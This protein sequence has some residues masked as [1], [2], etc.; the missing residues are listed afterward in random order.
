MKTKIAMKIL[1]SYT[2]VFRCGYCDLQNICK[3]LEPT[4]YNAGVYGWNCDIYTHGKF[5]AITTG[6]RNMKGERI[7]DN[8]IIKYDK[9]ARQILEKRLTFNELEKELAK[10][11]RNFIKEL[12]KEF[13]VL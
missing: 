1:N 11:R 2:K 10:N 12:I 3:F 8:I 13:N 6:Y 4:Y 5:I 9:I 7:P